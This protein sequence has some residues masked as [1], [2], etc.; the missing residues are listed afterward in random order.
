MKMKVLFMLVV[1]L[2]SFGL[3]ANSCDSD[4]QV[5][6]RN[7][8]EAADNFEIPRRIIFYNAITDTYM[9]TV[10]GL[11][12][13]HVDSADNQLE[14]TCKVPGGFIKH[15]LGMADNV[16]YFVEQ[17]SPTPVSTFQYRVIYK[18]TAII[19]AMELNIP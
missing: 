13:I 17:L 11:C 19:P 8:S 1:V 10:E 7:L 5:A 3:M 4:A 15:Y 12:S 2:L 14:V 18:P 16:N 6:S 9:Y